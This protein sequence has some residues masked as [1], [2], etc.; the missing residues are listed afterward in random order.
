MS[1][2]P[3]QTAFHDPENVMKIGFPLVP[4][5]HHLQHVGKTAQGNGYWIT[6]QVANENGETRDFLAAYVF[7][8]SGALI[9]SEVVDHGL[10]SVQT[11]F[12]PKET[13]QKLKRKIDAKETAEILVKPFSVSFYGHRFGL[14]IRENE[15][16]SP[17]G[18]ET[19]IDAMPGFTLLF[20][21]PWSQCNYDT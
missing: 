21:G 17:A 13:I 10:R 5:D 16:G 9:S 4:D 3:N 18:D 2:G 14:I 11:K 6:W 8:K 19:F 7:D 1:D 15:E 12:S 20:Y